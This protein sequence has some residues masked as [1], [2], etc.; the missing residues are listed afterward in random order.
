MVK[1]FSNSFPAMKYPQAGKVY[2]YSVDEFSNVMD[3]IFMATG[4]FGNEEE[5][6]ELIKPKIFT[7]G[8]TD[9][10]FVI[11]VSKGGLND[12]GIL[13]A[14]N[15][16]PEDYQ[17]EIELMADTSFGLEIDF[18]F[19]LNKQTLNKYFDSLNKLISIEDFVERKRN[20]STLMSVE[21]TEDLRRLVM[22]VLESVVKAKKERGDIM[23]VNPIFKAR[24]L[25]IDENMCFCALPF[26]ED[27]LEIMDEIIKPF[28]EEKFGIS[29]LRSG[30]IFEPN[31]DI[32]ETIW[33]YINQ[34]G[35]VIVDISDQNP[36]V[37]YELG[38]CHTLG[39]KVIMLCDKDSLQEDYNGKLPFDIGNMYTIF[40]KNSGSGPTKLTEEI[41]K[42]VTAIRTGR[43][44][45]D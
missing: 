36:N 20:I 17:N 30:T 41:E 22:G 11:G 35:F 6:N 32:K 42:M 9:L 27:R 3:I 15:Q 29:V 43:P 13:T 10:D 24:N 39:K 7:I 14:V 4:F 31:M 1:Y 12:T 21:G 44:V 23:N 25:T 28:L 38:I 40:Y 8:R 19:T 34:A 18:I 37:F 33:T 5:S 45:T 16:L 2:N 26:T